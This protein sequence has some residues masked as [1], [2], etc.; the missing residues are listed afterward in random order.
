VFALSCSG[1]LWA[2]SAGATDS[3]PPANRYE[4]FP[5]PDI[6][7]S[8]DIGAEV[9]VAFTLARFHGDEYP[10][11]WLLSGV[12][13]TSFKDDVNGFRAVQQY[14]VLR[15][16]LPNLFSGRVRIDTRI[17]FWRAIDAGYYGLGNASV[18]GGLPPG[19]NPSRIDEYIA[20]ETR[21]RSTIR[22]KTGTPL[23]AAFGVNL[24]YETP[25]VYAGSKLAADSSGAGGVLGTQDAF[26]SSLA[27]GIILDTRDN[28]FVPKRGV[29]DQIGVAG[30]VGSAERVEY[31]E[32]SATLASYVPIVRGVTFATRLMSSF[33]L[34]RVPFYDL[35]QG[36]VFSQQYMI[37]SDR[38]VRGVRQGRY[39]GHAKLL[40]NTELR[41]TLIPR[42]RVL[43][44][45]LQ[46]GTTTFV[47][48]GRVWS[49]YTTPELDGT[50]PGIKVGTG[51]G[52]FFQWDRS[53]V[54]RVE[55]AYSPSERATAGLPFSIYIANGLAF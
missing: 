10:Y 33:Q 32:A 18:A 4:F 43:S 30:T 16:D 54:F 13:S 3:D 1:A 17:N 2:T 31:G 38:G 40:L 36:G 34:G 15:L 9:G 46:I 48:L 21:L 6:G 44:W 45:Q 37:G 14:H 52:I 50:S 24:R 7:G 41:T 53:S 35:E 42:F 27:A 20:E 49:G 22:V 51:A 26:L 12:V 11:R 19:P 28:E 23:D 25:E 47:D 29:Y 8:S 39:A 5:V 55:A